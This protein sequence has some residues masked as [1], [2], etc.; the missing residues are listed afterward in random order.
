MLQ[1]LRNLLAD[2]C[3]LYALPLF[4]SLLPWTLGFR[5]LKWF[6]RR[7]WLYPAVVEPA[8]EVARQYFPDCDEKIWK[9]RFRLLRLVDHADSYLTLLRGARWW[10]RRIELH[11]DWPAAGPRVFLTYHWGGGQWIWRGLRAHG[12]DAYF[13]AQRAQGRALGITRLSHWYGDFR[14]WAIRRIGSRGPWFVGGSKERLRQALQSG[15]SVVGMLDLPAAP[16]Q[17]AAETSLLGRCVRFPLGLARLAVETGLPV[18]L[19]S[20]AFDPETGRRLLWI[21]NLQPAISVDEVM[22]RYAEHLEA[23]LRAYPEYWQLWRVAP[24]MFCA[25]TPPQ[26]L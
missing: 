13:V 5:L 22:H 10:E 15:A 6:A 3:A 16:Q 14:A 2:A 18:T 23:R 12:F 1:R 19:F 17:R 7:D 4:V 9:T 25:E 20:A 21:E 24:S 11:G 8:W 26:A